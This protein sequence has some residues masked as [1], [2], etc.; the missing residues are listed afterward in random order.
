MDTSA[1]FLYQGWFAVVCSLHTTVAYTACGTLRICLTR[2]LTRHTVRDVYITPV[3]CMTGGAS[4]ICHTR[5][6]HTRRAHT[7]RTHGRRSSRGSAS[8]EPMGWIR[9]RSRLRS[10]GKCSDGCR[11]WT[12]PTPCGTYGGA[13][14]L[15]HTRHSHGSRCVA[16]MSHPSLTRQAVCYV[17]V[18]RGRSHDKRCVTYMSQAV[19]HT[20]GGA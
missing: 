12:C 1:Y 15:C 8:P 19:A 10:R 16:Y 17:L 2:S 4:R 9:F 3:N 18:T 11:G 14:R 13:L 5:R 7:R 20:A 6:T